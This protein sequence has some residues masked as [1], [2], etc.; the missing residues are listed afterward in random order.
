M[1]W[2][3]SLIPAQ[4]KLIGEAILALLLVFA[5]WYAHTVWDGY[6]EGKKVKAE[7]VAARTGEVNIIKSYTETAKEIHNAKDDPC[8]Y[9]N[10]PANIIRVLGK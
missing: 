9:R 8:V 6:V 4:Y 3:L 5:G 2:I 1:T 10:I 7:V